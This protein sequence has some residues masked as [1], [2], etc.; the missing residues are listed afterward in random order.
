MLTHRRGEEEEEGEDSAPP[1][2]RPDWVAG[3]EAEAE[4]AETEVAEAEG[5]N[6]AAREASSSLVGMTQDCRCRRVK[7]AMA[8][9]I[10]AGSR[11]PAHA[12]EGPELDA[13][14]SRGY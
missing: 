13:W 1:Q 10:D 2:R 4:A 9:C 8:Q 12:L 6:T 5:I 14:S 7:R 11:I 3:E